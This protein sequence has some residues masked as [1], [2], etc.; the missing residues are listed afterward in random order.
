ILIHRLGRLSDL[1]MHLLFHQATTGLA[2]ATG[3]AL[4]FLARQRRESRTL[5]DPLIGS[6]IPLFCAEGSGGS[7]ESRLG[8]RLADGRH[9]V[10]NSAL[11]DRHFRNTVSESHGFPGDRRHALPRNQNAHQVQRISCGDRDG[12][13]G[14]WYLPDGAYRLHRYRQRKL[15]AEKSIDEAPT[16]NLSTILKPPEGHQQFSPRG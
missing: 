13:S 8:D 4:H 16:A 5:R 2:K 12:L 6:A 14:S 11:R 1:A 10:V 7:G 9:V 15:L 3:E